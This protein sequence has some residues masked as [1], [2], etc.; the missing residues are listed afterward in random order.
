MNPVRYT[1]TGTAN[2]AAINL[3]YRQNPFNVGVAAVVAGTA[4]FSVQ[5]TYDDIYSGTFNAATATWFTA[6]AFSAKTA[7]T[8]GAYT[9]P[10]V[11]IRGIVS[12]ATGTANVGF[13]FIQATNSP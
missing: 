2:G 8:D 5:H 10:I 7:S 4:T 12:A 13:T 6:T 1:V 11:A 3:D 9:T